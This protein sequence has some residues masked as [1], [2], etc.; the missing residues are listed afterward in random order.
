M[1]EKEDLY[2]SAFDVNV[3]YLL[4]LSGLFISLLLLLGEF[5]HLMLYDLLQWNEFHRQT[6][7]NSWKVLLVHT[8]TLV[9]M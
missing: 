8:H 4:N 1:R 3:V 9:H 5:M 6:M 7:K 2:S